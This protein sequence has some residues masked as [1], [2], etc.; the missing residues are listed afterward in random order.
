MVDEGFFKDFEAIINKLSVKHKIPPSRIKLILDH[1]FKQLKVYLTDKRIP[2]VVITNWGTFRPSSANI[3]RALSKKF[4]WYR[5]GSVEPESMRTFL[6]RVWPIYRRLMAERY[7]WGMTWPFWNKVDK[8]NYPASY[9]ELIE[10]NEKPV[11]K[12]KR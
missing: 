6:R 10:S 1:F 11:K 3:K 4:Y 7:R 2:K 9:Y 12:R 8:D 5:L